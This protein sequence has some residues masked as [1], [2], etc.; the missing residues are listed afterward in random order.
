M[1]CLPLPGEASQF[2]LRMYEV[3]VEAGRARAAEEEAPEAALSDAG[4]EMAAAVFS[5]TRSISIVSPFFVSCI[6]FCP[7]S[8]CCLCA[9]KIEIEI[10]QRVLQSFC[11]IFY[12][13]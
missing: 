2:R 5:S 10:L 1:P 8:S 6:R 9:P 4:V 3:G 12:L 11:F 13:L 7:F